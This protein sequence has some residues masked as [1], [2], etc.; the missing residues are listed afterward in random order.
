[1]A[2]IVE[3]SSF[4]KIWVAGNREGVRSL[5]EQIAGRLANQDGT[6][7][8]RNEDGC[9]TISTSEFS[10]DV[11]VDGDYSGFWIHPPDQLLDEDA[12]RW[13]RFLEDF[14]ESVIVPVKD[15]TGGVATGIG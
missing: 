9:L 12:P 11:D 5:L 3:K 6:K 2:I 14:H 4:K 1:M 13:N 8:H 15:K 7:V 10:F